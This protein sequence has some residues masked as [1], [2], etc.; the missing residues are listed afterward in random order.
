MGL[1]YKHAYCI[2]AAVAATD[3]SIGCF[4]QEEEGDSM[5]LLPGDD[6]NAAADTSN[7]Y[8]AKPSRKLY[9]DV[10]PMVSAMLTHIYLSSFRLGVFY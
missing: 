3:G 5:V 9:F 8:I 7:A 6:N 10:G 1:V 2:I 4:V